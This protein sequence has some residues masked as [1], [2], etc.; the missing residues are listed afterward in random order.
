MARGI[1][2]F[3]AENRAFGNQGERRQMNERDLLERFV[4][5]KDPEAFRELI[6]RHGAM[7]L[8]VCRSI[9]HEPH[10]AEDCFQNVFLILARRAN[11]IKHLDTIAPWLHRVALRVARRARAKT[12]QRRAREMT[13]PGRGPSIPRS[14]LTRRSYRCFAKRSASCPTDTGCRWFF[15]TWKG[16]PTRRPPGNCN[17]RSEPSRDGFRGPGRRFVTGSAAAAWIRP[18]IVRPDRRDLLRC[19]LRD[20]RLEECSPQCRSLMRSQERG[21][22]SGK[23]C[24]LRKFPVGFAGESRPCLRDQW[25]DVRGVAGPLLCKRGDDAISRRS[26][27]CR[28]FEPGPLPEGE[29]QS[30]AVSPSRDARDALLAVGL[31]SAGRSR[32]R[33]A[34]RGAA[35]GE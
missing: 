15:A 34:S 12:S 23:S 9:L 7:V 8:A 11:T 3:A 32:H 1:T 28:E 29:N 24:R 21:S 20:D 13:R 16:R 22:R 14:R 18:R 19:P 30:P 26:R 33:S 10:D 25:C 17:G 6:E 27:S 5:E 4:V 35:P 31:A 2:P